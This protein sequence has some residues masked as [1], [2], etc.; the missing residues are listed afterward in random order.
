MMRVALKGLLGRKLR[1][2]LT[3]FAIVLGVGMVSGS[4]VLTDTIQSSYDSAYDVSYKNAD[5]V[6]SAKNA[7]S[8]GTEG[9]P[10][11][12]SDTV[13]RRVRSLPEV[14][15]TF[16]SVGG[17][18]GLVGRDGKTIGRGGS[19]TSADPAGDQSLNQLELVRGAWPHGQGEIAIDK[20]T[21]ED[22]N[23]EIGSTIGAFGDGAV[24]QFRIAGIVE[25]KSSQLN[26]V[27][28]AAVFDLATAQRL[29]DKQGKL[30][31]I[32]VAA[33]DGVSP[34]ALTKAVRPL[35]PQNAQARTAQAQIDKASSDTASGLGSFRMILLAFGAIAL[36]V[37]SFVIANTMSI[38]VAQRMRELAT[39]RTL[40]ASR[41]QVLRSV[42]LEAVVV[43][44]LASIAGLFLGIGLA[45]GLKSLLE[46]IGLGLPD[47]GIV[48]ATRTV[49]VSLIVG[50]GI[51]LLASLR[52]A[53]R[54]TRVEPIAAVREGATLPQSRL[55][56]YGI[57]ASL[58]VVAF[59]VLLL[60]YGVFA[61]GLA[62]GVRMLALGIGSVLLFI[63]VA[64]I[65]PRLVRPLV[66]V[67]G[68]PGARI[69]GAAG[70]LAR[71]NARRNPSRTAS[72][73]AAL[74]IGLALITF[75]AILGQGL[76][77]S[78]VDAVDKQFIADY[79]VLST[80]NPVTDK[81][82]RAVAKVPS[83]ETVSQIRLGS[84]RAFGQTIDV[85]G[86][87]GN[88]TK[89]VD[90]TWQRGSDS[91]PAS[92]GRHGAIV[93]E[94]YAKSHHL[95]VG[96]P[97]RLKSPTGQVVHLKVAAIFEE[98]KGGSPF[99]RIAMSI[100]TYD[101]AFSS[102]ENEFV[103]VNIDGGPGSANTAKLNSAL[104]AFPDADVQTRDEFKD[105]QIRGL[106]ML[107]NV[108]YALL[109]LSVV[110][111][112]FGIV[113]TLVLSVFER[114][115]ELGMLRAVGM[116]RRQVRRMIRHESIVTALVGAT[117]G[118]AIGAF[119]AG[120]VTH[121]W[122]DAGFVFAVPVTTLVV[123]VAVAI[124]A[125]M[126]AAIMPARRAA[127]LNVLEALQYE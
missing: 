94:K 61:H 83:V 62:T 40:G 96:S 127:R 29:L 52:P 26:G 93:A 95:A 126:A 105:T 108:V 58:G 104:V 123:F 68:A 22:K 28:P 77:S 37:G 30:D 25:Y 59:A 55:S 5:A 100:P 91:V 54:A 56:R 102:H 8:S 1:A 33:R 88:L 73:A 13:L 2:T 45:L 44:L 119:L 69:A 75:V 92:L 64:L 99:G 57:V 47:G 97:L 65:A 34:A 3:A 118:I 98:P 35:L 67:L 81:A 6:V 9:Q 107:L 87:D 15:G 7:I 50:T 113:N 115:R 82:A 124:V 36:F 85:N 116:T 106:K 120:L 76:R 32:Q 70:M 21:A 49:V 86:V 20:S 17:P 89:V 101:A 63:G 43:G 110:V 4:F 122:S 27:A 80:G 84:A 79:G 48:L 109:G 72:T 31:E 103:L 11:S 18:V 46:A 114:T 19:A 111:S 14:A 74:M 121:A 117:F 39:L 38:T 24:R 23:Y 125:G 10:Q 71:D 53:L 78:F 16:A 42:V 51:A 12:F 41:R 60:G 112:L 90:M 66:A